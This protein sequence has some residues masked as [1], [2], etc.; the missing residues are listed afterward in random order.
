VSYGVRFAIDFLELRLGKRV[1]KQIIYILLLTFC[2][3]R[4]KIKEIFGASDATLAKYSSA[5]RDEDLGRVFEQNY[6]RPQSE[7]EAYRA[8]I[9]KA[10]EEKPPATRREAAVVIEKI[11][12]IKRS[13]TQVGKFLKKGA[14]KPSSRFHAE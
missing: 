2:V 6:N 1:A 3:E 11:T 13:L 7:L 10:F 4:K 8:Q 5:L 12:G 14:K 9:E